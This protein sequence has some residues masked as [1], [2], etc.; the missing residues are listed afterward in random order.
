VAEVNDLTTGTLDD[1]THDVN[2]RVVAVKK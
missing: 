2:G 1:A